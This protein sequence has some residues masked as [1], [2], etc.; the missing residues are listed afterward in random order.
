MREPSTLF[1]CSPENAD[2]EL[3]DI[4]K[5]RK[6]G[7][8]IHEARSS[9]ND[10]VRARRVH[11]KDGYCPPREQRTDVGFDVTMDDHDDVIMPHIVR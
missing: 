11:E 8:V 6:H 9:H 7:V 1:A 3:G 10:A 4:R 5:L 2:S